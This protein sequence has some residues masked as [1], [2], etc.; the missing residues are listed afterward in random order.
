M[1]ILPPNCRPVEILFKNLL[2]RSLLADLNY[3]M[4]QIPVRVLPGLFDFLS[5][6]GSWGL[7]LALAHRLLRLQEHEYS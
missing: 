2:L 7:F 5:E 1:D 6:P 3:T 4:K